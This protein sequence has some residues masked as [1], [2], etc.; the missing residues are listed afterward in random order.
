MNKYSVLQRIL[1]AYMIWAGLKTFC[2]GA[3][4]IT[5]VDP[6]GGTSGTEVTILGSGFTGTSEV[7]FISRPTGSRLDG[8]FSV[9]SDSEVEASAPFGSSK[10]LIGLFT[11]LGATITIPPD[12]INVTSLLVSGGGGAVWV[13]RNGASLTNPGS[14][15]NIVYVEEGGPYN[16]LGGGSKTVFVDSGGSFF[17]GSLGGGNAVFYEPGANIVTGNGITFTEVPALQP[18]FPVF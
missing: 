9:I 10:W 12:F 13:V 6:G 4:L 8:A 1:F 2:L 14:G 18:S 17:P 5:S 16:L 7:L 15:S 3:A 11:D